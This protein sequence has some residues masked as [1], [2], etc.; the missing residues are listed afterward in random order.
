MAFSSFTATKQ[1]ISENCD[2]SI[3]HAG[4]VLSKIV[5]LFAIIKVSLR[6]FTS[7]WFCLL[8]YVEFI[9]EL[10]SDPGNFK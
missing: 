5:C 6:M 4:A 2:E 10:K 7:L 1:T 8:L 3:N 9:R